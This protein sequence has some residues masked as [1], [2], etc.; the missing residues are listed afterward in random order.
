M[1]HGT[2]G[3]SYITLLVGL[4]LTVLI[5]AAL[6]GEL[7][8]GMQLVQLTRA[9]TEVLNVA[10]AEMEAIRGTAFDRL[11]GFPVSGA[12]AVGEIRVEA[13]TPRRKRVSVFL[14][15]PRYPNQTVT[16]VTYVHQQGLN[17]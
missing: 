8:H 13:L 17:P 10:Q 3:F 16:L 5:A 9:R 12:N 2:D 14:Q 7:I 15:H 1:R 6:C 4:S 11:V